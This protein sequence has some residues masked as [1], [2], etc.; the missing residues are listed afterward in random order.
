MASFEKNQKEKLRQKRKEEKRKKKEERAANNSKGSGLDAMMAYVDAHGNIVDTPPDPSE[1]VEIDAESIELGVP[2]RV[3][4]E[5]D[6]I[7]KGKVDY[8][9][10]SKGYGF[11][12]DS[13]NGEKYFL[14]ISE[15]L[16]DVDTGSKV[17]FELERG[18]RGMNAVRVKIDK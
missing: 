18:Q 15:T 3:K 16:E 13:D 1:K 12:L 4:E 11:V 17:I 9:D 8:F 7:R 14:H 10:H 5:I 6:P 2:E